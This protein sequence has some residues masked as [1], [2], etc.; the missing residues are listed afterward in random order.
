[1]F[2]TVW[3]VRVLGVIL[4]NLAGTNI[5]ATILLTKIVH[6]AQLPASSEEAAALTLAVS[7][8]VL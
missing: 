7:I 2:P 6:A 1:M 5:G 4:C 3:L 8:S